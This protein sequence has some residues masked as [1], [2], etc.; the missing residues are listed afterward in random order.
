MADTEVLYL[1]EELMPYLARYA[2]SHVDHAAT[3]SGA[4]LAACLSLLPP[5]VMAASNADGMLPLGSSWPEPER[6]VLSAR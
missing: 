1:K 2:E 5:P 3:R 6:M 4:R